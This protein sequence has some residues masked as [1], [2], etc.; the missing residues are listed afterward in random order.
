MSG[1]GDGKDV[2]VQAAV[3]QLRAGAAPVGAGT[4]SPE[5]LVELQAAAIK[6]LQYECE[7]QTLAASA[8]ANIAGCMARRL[9]ELG[10]GEPD[11]DLIIPKSIHE[12]MRGTQ[13]QLSET[14]DGDVRVHVGDV[15]I[16]APLGWAD[17]RPW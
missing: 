8:L 10:Y 4:P 6:G 11:G 5:S 16:P 7:K 17:R 13:I 3:A 14:A 2:V 15:E 1:N 12:Q 9:I